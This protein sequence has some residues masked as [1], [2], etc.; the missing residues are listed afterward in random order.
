MKF[1]LLFYATY[2]SKL[3]N[4]KNINEQELEMILKQYQVN[5]C[6]KEYIIKKREKNYF[7][8][9]ID[10]IKKD[11]QNQLP[12]FENNILCKTS[13]KGIK[14]LAQNT[15]MYEK[16]LCKEIW[17]A[18]YDGYGKYPFD[19]IDIQ[20]PLKPKR[21]YKY[22]EIDILGVDLNNNKVV[23]YLI[24]AKPLSTKETLLRA[25]IEA[26]TYRY[27]IEA[28]KKNFIADFIKYIK[29]YQGKGK[30]ANQIKELVLK[31]KNIEVEIE[32]LIE[33][34]SLILVP[35][36]L[37]ND[38]YSKRVYKEY[39]NDINYYYVTYD[40]EDLEY[41]NKENRKST[42]FKNDKYPKIQKIEII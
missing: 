20:T 11:Y 8:H 3:N 6:P 37:Y 19:I 41:T 23:I 36:N 40:N 10:K 18:S 34:Q 12:Y 35:Q 31:S 9:N 14:K 21:E 5:K 29:N 16:D 1:D 13:K 26:I 2:A 33:T 17:F 4:Y 42:L 38:D 30:K 22:G 28:N 32:S 25:S 39:S 7:V 15:S 27:I 24:E